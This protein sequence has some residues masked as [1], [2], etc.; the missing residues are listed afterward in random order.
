MFGK[1]KQFA[2]KKVLQS[3]MKGVPEEQQKMIME[4]IEKDPA[5]FEKIAKEM[6]AELKV[7]GNNQMAAAQKVLP[8]YQ[9]E[10]MAVMSPE[11]KEQLMKMQMGS[12]GRFNPNG[13]IRN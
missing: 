2:L 13:T 4:M 3:Q 9:A 1:L 12:Q 10:I 5:L 6:Q 7:N 11:M 8:K